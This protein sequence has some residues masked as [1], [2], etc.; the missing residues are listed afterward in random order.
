[1]RDSRNQQLGS[2]PRGE[3]EEDQNVSSDDGDDKDGKAEDADE[4]VCGDGLEQ[5]C[6]DG[7]KSL[8][9]SSTSSAG[10]SSDDDDDDF[11]SASSRGVEGGRA[12][13]RKKKR[14]KLSSLFMGTKARLVHVGFM[15]TLQLFT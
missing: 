7:K 15:N 11:Q 8:H 1:M 12:F 6:S 3:D 2:G 5:D 14:W 4:E 9:V 13:L 10:S